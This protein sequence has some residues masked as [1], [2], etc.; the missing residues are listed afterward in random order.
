MRLFRPRWGTRRGFEVDPWESSGSGNECGTS[1]RRARER[2]SLVNHTVCT[3]SQVAARRNLVHVLWL[4]SSDFQ[5]IPGVV[6]EGGLRGSVT[7]SARAWGA[8][9]YIA[10]RLVQQSRR[11]APK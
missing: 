1:S 6:G 10:C 4:V 7:T 9:N 11:S 2:V 3:T 5:E 8:V